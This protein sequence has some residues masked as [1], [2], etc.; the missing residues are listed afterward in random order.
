MA[1]N[2]I[3]IKFFDASYIMRSGHLFLYARYTDIL[4][5]NLP[6]TEHENARYGT[7]FVYAQNIP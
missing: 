5:W 7:F 1:F 2:R 6:L 3:E 4:V